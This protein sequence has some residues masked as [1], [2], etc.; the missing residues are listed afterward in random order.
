MTTKRVQEPAKEE[1]QLT[2]F[3]IFDRVSMQTALSVQPM[4]V[5][6]FETLL[7]LFKRVKLSKEELDKYK[8]LPV[9]GGLQVMGTDSAS[10]DTVT[11]LVV[12]DA[13][14]KILLRVINGFDR[15]TLN[16]A[17]R[18]MVLVAKLEGKPA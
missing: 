8:L 13:E 1:K 4:R 18:I 9:A 11:D 2:G 12:S 5:G 14:A 10:P 6:D 16:E 7:P 17:E 15:W 3:T